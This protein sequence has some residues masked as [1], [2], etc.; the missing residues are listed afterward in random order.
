[1]LKVNMSIGIVCMV[2]NTAVSMLA[3]NLENSATSSK[4]FDGNVTSSHFS[5]A[6]TCSGVI[7]HQQ[8]AVI[9]FTQKKNRQ[10]L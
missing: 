8:H 10:I 4:L 2:N 3:T 5:N 6:G 9:C 1:M 7:S